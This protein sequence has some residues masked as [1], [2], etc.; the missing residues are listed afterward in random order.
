MAGPP[1]STPLGKH[2]HKQLNLLWDQL[3]LSEH[4]KG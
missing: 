2:F 4:K 1:R 3:P